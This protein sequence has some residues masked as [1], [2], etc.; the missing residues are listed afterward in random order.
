MSENVETLSLTAEALNA[1]TTGE[2][3][4]AMARAKLG[5]RYLPVCPPDHSGVSEQHEKNCTRPGKAPT[6]GKWPMRASDDPTVLNEWFGR[7]PNRNLGMTLGSEVGLVGF[8][9]DGEYGRK[10]MENLFDGDIPRTWQFSTPGGGS[11]FLFGV[12]KGQHLRKYTDA[13]L[14]A[15]HEELA[16]L[17]DGQMTVIPPSRHQNGGQYLWLPGRGPGDIPLAELP[18]KIL[19]KMLSGKVNETPLDLEVAVPSK[20]T[21]QQT[22]PAKTG[23]HSGEQLL[24][25]WS[26]YNTELPDPVLQK[27][28][29]NC[30]VIR[31]VVTEQVAFGCAEERWHAI[32]SMLV[33]AG[34]PN[35]ALAFS[36][37]SEKHDDHSER[38][39]RQMD[40]EGDSATYGPTRC[41]TLGCD[42]DQ[43]ARC[44]G[45]VRRSRRTGEPSNSPAAFLLN[46]VAGTAS[47]KQM[48]LASY[49]KLLSNR[50]SLND[51]SLCLVR[52]N[53]D[54]ALDYTPLANFVARISKTITRDDG[55]ERTTLYEIDGAII[56]SE[57]KLPP[58][59]VLASDF[60]SMKWLALW[61]PEP[62]I[63]PGSQIKDTVRHAIQTTA[64]GAANEQIFAHLGWVRIDGVWKY[65]HAGGALGMPNIK[66]ELDP[67]LK[68][69]ALPA[70]PSDPK[71][72]MKASLKLLGVAPLRVTLVLWSLVYL[73]PLCEMLRQMNLEPKFLVWLLGYTGTRKT[74]LAKLFLSHFG[75]LLEHPPASFKDTANSVEKRGFDTK[76]SLL[77]IDDFHPT[78][79]PQEK[80]AMEHLAQQILRGYG[81]RV[82]RGRM[83][84]DTTL[85]QDYPP[86]GMAIVTAEDMVSGGSSA[87]RLFPTE[88]LKNDVDLNRLT[89][90]QREARKLSAAMAG[91]LGWVGQAMNASRDSY[92]RLRDLFIEKRNEAAS[93]SVHGRL[94]EASAWLYVGLHFGLEYA[95]SVGAAEPEQRQRLLGEAWNVFLS[96]AS[97][98][99][100]KVAEVKASTRFVAIVSQLLANRSIYCDRVQW[101][102]VP[103]TVP[104]NSTHVGWDDDNYYYFL[105]ELIYNEVCQFLSKRG[106][107]FPVSAST[108]WKELADAGLTHT[109]I[110]KESGKERRHLLVK[111]TVRKQRQRLLW[112]K[113]DALNE[114]KEDKVQFRKRRARFRA[115]TE[116]SDELDPLGES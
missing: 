106:E 113:R 14:D 46:V 97:E 104:K 9:V 26:P 16:F 77:L 40:A 37:L 3:A 96:A 73:A 105:P 2:A 65:L 95:E 47:A 39:I 53:K 43:I 81:D 4:A 29:D 71:E 78:G 57:K 42:V 24:H 82:G 85:R 27:L 30:G 98:Q 18:N 23:K 32:T 13:N 90:A 63:L 55:A 103:G 108:L 83:K 80:R 35:A 34:Y 33:R 45:F 100:E 76:D 41:T 93:L 64:T 48:T 50:Y 11:R 114:K 1:M 10:K 84:Q 66:V 111:K 92:S 74:T 44:H 54:G 36:Q 28:A 94:V 68:N 8:D 109:E 49:S 5:P 15:E 91:Y 87:A 107:Q 67:R 20:V 115:E 51:S 72:A 6:I 56:S 79:S 58:I 12:P 17:A 7:H 116:E 22:K 75:D 31:E 112:M 89:E 25:K 69:Y 59:H 101:E 62:N 88:L 52:V 102:L 60:D 21:C 110:S 99:G 86:R 70:P 19:E 61:G 38:R